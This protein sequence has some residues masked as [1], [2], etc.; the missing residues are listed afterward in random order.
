[1]ASLAPLSLAANGGGAA[2]RIMAVSTDPMASEAWSAD[3]GEVVLQMPTDTR[4]VSIVNITRR[5]LLAVI[6]GA[7][8]DSVISMC[9]LPNGGVVTG[10]GKMDG[11]CQVWLPEQWRAPTKE[12]G[13]DDSTVPA[14]PLLLNKPAK[15]LHEP[16]Y[17]F[18]LVALPDAKAGSDLFALAAARY[19]Q[20]HVCL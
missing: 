18:A 8:V 15:R 3:P 12:E 6:S 19:N 20:I 17:S 16:G 7:H 1:M 5:T 10:G 4:A 2:D 14:T 9:S 11:S 13:V